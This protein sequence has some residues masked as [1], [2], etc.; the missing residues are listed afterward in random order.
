MLY[1][2]TVQGAHRILS[3]AFSIVVSLT[4]CTP[5]GTYNENLKISIFTRVGAWGVYTRRQETLTY[6]PDINVDPYIVIFELSST[7]TKKKHFKKSALILAR[8]GG[9]L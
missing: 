9:C 8:F 7:I 2:K 5:K 3:S 6:T 1:R 4:V